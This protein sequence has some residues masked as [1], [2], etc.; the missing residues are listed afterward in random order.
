MY[1][2]TMPGWFW[3]IYYG[4]LAVTFLTAVIRIGRKRKFVMEILVLILVFSI[5]VVGFLNSA[6]SIRL[7]EQ[8]EV[9]FFLSQLQHG[10]FWTIFS[11][12]GYCLM[13]VWWI[14]LLVEKRK[15]AVRLSTSRW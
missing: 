5:P 3:A 15:M 12:V 13:L 11:V 14:G 2:E 1:W 6:E 7:V 10:A 4:F 8:N 9:E